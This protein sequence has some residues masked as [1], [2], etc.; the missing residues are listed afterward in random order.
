M[1]KKPS[2]PLTLS[3]MDP[4]AKLNRSSHSIATSDDDEMAM[5]QINSNILEE[6]GFDMDDA[7]EDGIDDPNLNQYG[8]SDRAK[9]LRFHPPPTTLH[10][11]ASWS[12]GSGRL[13]QYR[14]PERLRS[15]NIDPVASQLL[16]ACVL[17]EEEEEGQEDQ[18]PLSKSTSSIGRM[19]RKV[20]APRA[21]GRRPLSPSIINNLNKN[22]GSRMKSPTVDE[23]TSF[24][25]PLTPVPHFCSAKDILIGVR[26]DFDC[27]ARP[28]ARP[29]DGTVVLE[30]AL[31]RNF[32]GP[33]TGSSPNK[34]RLSLPRHF[35]P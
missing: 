29:A 2:H 6:F 24:N 8:S 5:M 9:S 22:Q 14:C 34:R 4:F 11:C 35:K 32:P 3:P 30:A 31:H 20:G 15:Q 23:E 25:A 10:R 13:Q 7:G 1:A 12:P 21:S 17:H 19:R 18:D 27:I 28:V 26:A 16:R 33:Q